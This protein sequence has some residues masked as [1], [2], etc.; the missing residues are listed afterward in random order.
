ML[1]RSKQAGIQPEIQRLDNKTSKDLINAIKEKGLKYQIAS[2]GNHRI[3]AVERQIRTLK[4]HMLAFLIGCHPS[5]PAN[6]W[7][8]I[9]PQCVLTINMVQPSQINPRKLAYNEIWGNFDYNATPLGPPGCNVVVHDRDHASWGPRG[10]QGWYITRAEDHYRNHK[11][12]MK[13]TGAIKISDAVEFFPHQIT[14]PGTLTEDRLAAAFDDLQA[15]LNELHWKLPLILK[16][17]KTND[18]LEKLKK[19]FAPPKRDQKSYLCSLHNINSS[20][21]N[22]FQF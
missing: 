18:A 14:M 22:C 11:C 16:G 6:C 4:T 9:I 19:I 20:D 3:L 5:F 2:P 21:G 17:S 8:L 10:T 7:D 1:F 12:L 15:A 13:E